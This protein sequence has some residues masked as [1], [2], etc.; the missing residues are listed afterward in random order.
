MPAPYPPTM[1][2]FPDSNVTPD[3]RPSAGGDGAEPERPAASVPPSTALERPGSSTPAD[4]NPG[5]AKPLLLTWLFSPRHQPPLC[6]VPKLNGWSPSPPPSHQVAH[7]DP[8]FARLTSRSDLRRRPLRSLLEPGTGLDCLPIPRMPR[9]RERTPPP[10][11]SDRT[12]GKLSSPPPPTMGGM[13]AAAPLLSTSSRPAS[14]GRQ[15]QRTGPG[16]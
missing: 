10:G 13:G 3:L 11:G 12:R 4:P 14:S 9:G 5:Q 2:S 16:H 15:W 1:V 6:H 8:A 7:S